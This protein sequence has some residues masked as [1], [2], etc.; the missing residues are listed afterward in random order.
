MHFNLAFGND[1]K[2]RYSKFIEAYSK[3]FEFSTIIDTT[4][5]T[6]SFEKVKEIFEVFKINKN[7]LLKLLTYK[8]K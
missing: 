4:L 2:K 3:M 6:L 1:Y 8:L 5:Y 7:Y